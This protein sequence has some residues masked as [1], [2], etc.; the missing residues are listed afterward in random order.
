MAEALLPLFPLSSISTNV[1]VCMSN[2][3]VESTAETRVSS[4]ELQVAGG[5]KG[6]KVSYPYFMAFISLL[7]NME[8]LKQIHDLATR[9]SSVA[10]LTK[11]WYEDCDF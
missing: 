2:V 1:D 7:N 6:K 10:A 11:G 8:L 9:R 5:G 4:Y 3:S